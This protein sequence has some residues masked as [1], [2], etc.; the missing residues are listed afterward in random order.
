[1]KTYP[2]DRLAANHPEVSQGLSESERENGAETAWQ[3]DPTMGLTTEYRE[4][5][6]RDE[7]TWCVDH[8]C[9][10]PSD[11]LTGR[12]K[13]ACLCRE[14]PTDHEAHGQT[15][16]AA[17]EASVGDVPD[18]EAEHSRNMVVFA[19]RLA[20]RARERRGRET[21]AIELEGDPFTRSAWRKK[22]VVLVSPADHERHA[23]RDGQ[24][25]SSTE[26]TRTT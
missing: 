11:T 26:R 22:T 8:K 7:H 15:Q 10:A 21:R 24:A 12:S 4:R 3:K 13:R 5:T 2:A 20:T 25:R 14:V 18:A 16:R 9:E 17:A 19:L 23:G 1:M 6:V